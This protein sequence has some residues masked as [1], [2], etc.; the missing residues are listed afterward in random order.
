MATYE[1]LREKYTEEALSAALLSK[2][3]SK[4]DIMRR[5]FAYK[6]A[7]GL[8]EYPEKKA[9]IS[10]F[11]KDFVSG[12]GEGVV[13]K[14]TNYK[15]AV[16]EGFNESN[17]GMIIN[18]EVP[19]GS[20]DF[21]LD[22]SAVKSITS[23]L[24][25]SPFYLVGGAVGGAVGGKVGTTMGMF[26]FEDAMRS[27]LIDYYKNGEATSFSDFMSK[28]KDI[29]VVKAFKEGGK[30]AVTGA[31]VHGSNIN[32]KAAKEYFL[33][34]YGAEGF[35]GQFM[36]A[37]IDTL[38]PATGLTASTSLLNREIPTLEDF[39]N[40]AV[41]IA[42]L[43]VVSKATAPIKAKIKDVIPSK[44]KTPNTQEANIETETTN[45]TVEGS[46]QEIG[47]Q[48]NP[49]YGGYSIKIG[50]IPSPTAYWTNYLMDMWAKGGMTPQEAV[51]SYRNNPAGLFARQG[52][53]T[54]MIWGNERLP[55]EYQVVEAKDLK[56]SHD[57]E[58]N[59]NKDFPEYMQNR[60][61]DRKS[62]QEQINNIASNFMPELSVYGIEPQTGAPVVTAEGYVI[63]GNGRVEAIKLAKEKGTQGDYRAIAED[64]D[65]RAKDMENPI[66][67]R[68][69]Q[70]EFSEEQIRNLVQKGNQSNTLKLS[71]SEMAK[72][73]ASRLDDSLLDKLDTNTELSS[74]ENRGFIDEALNKII[75]DNEKGSLLDKDGKITNEGISRINNAML[76]KIIEDKSMLSKMIETEDAVLKKVSS[77][78]AKSS[79]TIS[80]MEKDINN[81]LINED[82]SLVKDVNDA[83]NLY[84]KFKKSNMTF[85][86][87]MK[88]GDMF[89]NISP[90]VAELTRIFQSS[91]G[92]NVIKDVI[93]DYSNVAQESS[94]GFSFDIPEMSKADILK[95][96]YTRRA[97]KSSETNLKAREVLNDEFTDIM[98]GESPTEVK[99]GKLVQ[100]DIYK[101]DKSQI[102]IS[103]SESGVA[104]SRH[105]IADRF[106]Q[107]IQDLAEVGNVPFRK[108]KM[109]VK[110]SILGFY[111]PRA[112]VI[113]T[114]G[115]DDLA[116]LVHETA[117]HLDKVLFKG[118]QTLPE[119]K[120]KVYANELGKIASK[121]DPFEEGFAEFVSHFVTNPEYVKTNTPK[122]YEHF[123]KFMSE[124][125][126]EIL[127]ILE[128]TQADY[129]L[130]REQP[131]NKRIEGQ[132]AT[133]KYK[134]RTSFKKLL[135]N[136]YTSFVDDLY[137]LKVMEKEVLKIAKQRNPN[138]K[139]KLIPERSP[140]LLARLNRG[141]KEKI[142]H[143]LVEEA[144][145]SRLEPVGKSLR[146]LYKGLT[147]QET[148]NFD[149]YLASKR[150]LTLN[151]RGIQTGIG[152]ND[153]KKTI[154]EGAE[155]YEARAQEVYKYIKNLRDYL[156]DSDIL[157]E[158]RAQRMKELD[159]YYVPF[160]RVVD[161]TDR[162]IARKISPNQV[163]KSI[164]GSD[165]QLLPIQES[166]AEYTVRVIANADKNMIMNAIADLAMLE[167]SGKV[168]ERVQ[169]KKPVKL[170]KDSMLARKNTDNRLKYNTVEI[171]DPDTGDSLGVWDMTEEFWVNKPA[172]R[173]T[174]ITAI[175]AGKPMVYEVNPEFARLVNG[176]NPAEIGWIAKMLS[177]FS[178]TLRAG[179]TLTPEFM[180]KNLIRDTLEAFI[181]ARGEG[182]K[183]GV[184]TL[185][186]TESILK[187]SREYKDWKIAG[188]KMASFIPT[189]RKN[190]QKIIKN[191]ESNVKLMDET[192]YLGTAL[193]TLNLVNPIDR[194]RALS[195]ISEDS[196]RLGVYKNRYKYLK[197]RGWDDYNAKLGAAFSSREATLDFARVGAKMRGVNAVIAFINA[198]IQG[199]DKMARNVIKAPIRTINALGVL[200]LPSI[201]FAFANRGDEEIKDLNQTIKDENWIYRVKDGIRKLPKPQNAI[202]F[203]SIFERALESTDLGDYFDS[204][205]GGFVDAMGL[206][207]LG[208]IP[209]ALQPVV[210][211]WR[212]KSNYTN[213]PLIP[214]WQERLMPEYQYVESTT[215]T[216]KWISNQ[217]AGLFGKSV[218]PILLD[219]AVRDWSGGLGS[220]ALQL[221][222]YVSTG[223]V[224]QDIY[225]YEHTPF[226]RAFRVAYPTRGN[227][228]AYTDFMNE[229]E[230]IKR[231]YDTAKYVLNEGERSEYEKYLSYEGILKY[232]QAI[233]NLGKTQKAIAENE[234]LSLQE[235][236]TMTDKLI[237]I[238]INFSKQ[239][240]SLIETF[241][242]NNE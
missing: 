176:L 180:I 40:A 227:S 155:K 78:L 137:P 80:K 220:Y 3:Y 106:K 125:E 168:I 221:I 71:K 143:F 88:Q 135:D 223:S 150:A 60:E 226:F 76:G 66:I 105:A 26:A 27:I 195:E 95:E 90:S 130:Y 204:L 123:M 198:K 144:I 25:D 47:G 108:G 146:D 129:K 148:I 145:N 242:K 1:E 11:T 189:D 28:V 36:G 219:Q 34:K 16:K 136:L 232:R 187:N 119:G 152:T 147:P 101:G 222:D 54:Y 104:I 183:P 23:V 186:G 102:N 59:K 184:D 207:F 121:G 138:S 75:P 63:S 235:K 93:N 9:T 181:N 110:G 132:F 212:N 160:K 216:S 55:V 14:A 139:I 218:S 124:N 233:I 41:T 140:Y 12:F 210:E 190:I 116:T 177:P 100:S 32:A 171:V 194:A 214:A 65:P 111:K 117:H 206:N 35:K 49:N 188:G 122:F 30:G 6:Q 193:N 237:R 236:R 178:T 209:N 4:E 52:G 141:V 87:F 15:E 167:G 165:R 225:E 39:I 92:A 10:N 213:V 205:K 8:I 73:D 17:T 158:E 37:S 211:G 166:L 61:R 172:D 45:A 173:N 70:G 163:V 81:G 62:S 84:D 231:K 162:A 107:R 7:H 91:K 67:V 77:G 42:G 182:F 127:K 13:D 151:Q 22:E 18:K 161:A 97:T 57:S 5:E 89:T 197:D 170:P 109:Y 38:F 68:R 98:F 175:R 134:G 238:M 53:R 131:S 94:G 21:S 185:K 48:I 46:V 118:K 74:I 201:Y 29:D 128:E 217:L 72:D 82:Y 196:T 241:N 126:P 31:V 203:L 169:S 142:N 191:T 230:K 86:E 20:S 208:L 200:L 224:K 199:A 64:I 51:I 202:P 115:I 234:N 96:A 113:R 19:E 239:G 2:G 133:K 24:S 156:I 120:E 228:Q 85:D 79:P 43:H 153:A 58:G 83:L 154:K 179:S 56:T 114:R 157:S 149:V 69:L 164:K 215:E 159:P 33:K 240:N 50:D 112:E 174:E 192:G 99:V 229:S 44:N 103:Y